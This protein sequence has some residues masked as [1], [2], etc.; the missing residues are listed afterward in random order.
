MLLWFVISYWVILL[1][2]GLY[3]AMRVR[4][5]RDFAVAGRRP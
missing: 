4:N 5:T 3:A 2:I 1:G